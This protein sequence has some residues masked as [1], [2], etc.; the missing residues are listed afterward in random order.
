MR[1]L[2]GVP[3]LGNWSPIDWNASRFFRYCQIRGLRT[4]RV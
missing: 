3:S 2:R 4:N 1:L